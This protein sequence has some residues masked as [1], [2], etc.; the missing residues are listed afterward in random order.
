M[1]KWQGELGLIVHFFSF[2][3]MMEPITNVT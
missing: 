3:S 1:T 2:Y